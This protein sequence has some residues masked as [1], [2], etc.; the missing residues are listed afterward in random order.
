MPARRIALTIGCLLFACAPTATRAQSAAEWQT[1]QAAAANKSD[2][3]MTEANTHQGLLAQYQV[4]RHAY[5]GENSPAFRLVFAQY[6]SWYQ[7]FL[8]DYP[9]AMDSYSIGQPP[10]EDAGLVIGSAMT[11]QGVDASFDA[12][13]NDEGGVA[14]AAPGRPVA[15]PRNHRMVLSTVLPS[16]AHRPTATR[17]PAA[18]RFRVRRRPARVFVGPAPGRTATNR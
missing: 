4:M 7:S 15:M 12:S 6:I 1:L 17:L 18:S 9:A 11:N 13:A 5:A 2:K 16:T 10:L 3:I 14:S 8:G